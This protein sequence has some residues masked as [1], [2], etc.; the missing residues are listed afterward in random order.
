MATPN[1]V[2]V[3][4]INGLTT[5]VAVS[6]GATVLLAN[7]SGSNLVYKINTIIVSNVDGANACDLTLSYN[8][9]AGGAGTS[10]RIANTISVPADASLVVL[11]KNSQ[12]YLHEDKSIVCFASTSNDLEAL[13]SYEVIASG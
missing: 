6:S 9:S 4:T 3:T 2:G 1:I 5:F 13:I 8:T 12:I 11:D 10:F 7:S